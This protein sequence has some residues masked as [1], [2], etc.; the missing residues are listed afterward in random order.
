MGIWD[1]EPGLSRRKF[2]E[3]SEGIH[4]LVGRMVVAEDGGEAVTLQAGTAAVLP[5]GWQEPGKF[6][7]EPKSLVIF[8]T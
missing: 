8:T 3:H 6:R 7:N 2:L 5:I 1:A 4:V